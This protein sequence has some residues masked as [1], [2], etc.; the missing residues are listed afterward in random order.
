[1]LTSRSLLQILSS[2]KAK[3]NFH[4]GDAN[5]NNCYSQPLLYFSVI[6]IKAV[7]SHFAVMLW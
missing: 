7:L 5:D 6:D 1:M 4:S 2:L 3:A